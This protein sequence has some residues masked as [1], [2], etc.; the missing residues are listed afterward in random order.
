MKVRL[1]VLIIM[2]MATRVFAQQPYPRFDIEGH[3][4]ARGLAPENTIPSFLKALEMGVTTIEL[5]VVITKDRKVIVSHEPWM[6][7]AICSDGSGIAV[8]EKDEKK[9]NI[10]QLTYEEVRKFDCGSRGNEKF[11]QQ[12]KIK[13]EKPLLLDVILAVEDYIRNNSSYE[14]D[15]NI[16]IKCSKEGDGKFHPAPEEFSNLVYEVVDQ[17]LP[18]DRVIIQSFDFRV[19]KYWNKKYPDVRLA[20]LVE[21]TKSVETNLHD[22]GFKPDIYSPYFK[23]LTKSKVDYLHKQKIRVVPW[24][25]NEDAEMLSAKGMGVDGFITDYPDRAKK[26]RM[27][28][29]LQRK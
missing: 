17:Y 16:E 11:P 8:S 13:V 25:I 22:L 28:L 15:Y 4:G 26:F 21:N 20:C 1:F 9:Y 14:V 7:A 10:N 3:R 12:E 19:L 18:W 2:T 6:S 24:T 29:N 27:T 5:D 23:L